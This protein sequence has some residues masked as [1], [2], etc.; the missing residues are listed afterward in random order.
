MSVGRDINN[1]FQ[2]MP[3]L[4]IIYIKYLHLST[5]KQHLTSTMDQRCHH[6]GPWDGW[7]QFTWVPQTNYLGTSKF[8]NIYVIASKQS[9]HA[10]NQHIA[11]HYHKYLMPGISWIFEHIEEMIHIINHSRKQKRRVT[12][13]LIDLKNAFGE[14]RHSNIYF[15]LY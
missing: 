5:E 15:I 8:K 13:T 3:I 2:L 6:F 7:P 12:I 9:F 10:F 1:L 11:I 14:A 4:K